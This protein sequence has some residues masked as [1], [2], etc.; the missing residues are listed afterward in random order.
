MAKIP[1]DMSFVSAAVIPMAYCTAYHSLYNLGQIQ[2]QTSILIHCGAGGVGQAAVQLAKLVTEVSNIF[3]TVG[4][5]EKRSLVMDRYGILE[6]HVFSSRDLSFAAGVKRMTQGRGVDVVLNSLGGES[7]RL[8]M[9]CVAQFGRFIEIGLKDVDSF[10][11]IPM[12]P[13]SKSITFASVDLTLMIRDAPHVLG[14]VLDKVMAFICDQK[15]KPEASCAYSYSKL[16]DAFRLLQG[17]KNLGKVVAVP[18]ETDLVPVSG[19]CS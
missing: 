14:G 15:I 2:E 9:G 16:E 10:G 1:N 7:L 6:D 12:A 18:H 11:K 5:N 19:R 4:S 13:F 17:G 8:S 3:V